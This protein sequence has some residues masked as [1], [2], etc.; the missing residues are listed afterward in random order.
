MPAA[1]AVGAAAHRVID[2]IH[3]DAAHGR[4]DAAPALRTRLADRA[5]AVLLVADLADRRATIDVNFADLPGTQ[6]QLRVRAFTRQQ[7]HA[8]A[9]RAR[10]PHA[11]ARL[12]LDAVNRRA[13]RN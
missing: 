3:R 10:E 9:G 4:P 12:Q 11:F 6:P 7:L 5:Q 8:G 1:A 13:D 2:R